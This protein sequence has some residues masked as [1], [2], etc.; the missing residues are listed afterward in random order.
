[1][2]SATYFD[3]R[4]EQLVDV[5]EDHR[6]ELSLLLARTRN[7]TTV[8]LDLSDLLN[9]GWL[10]A[11]DDP[12]QNAK[13]RL[14]KEVA[15]SGP[16]IVVT[17]GRTDARILKK[18]L[19]II[20]PDLQDWFAFLDFEGTSAPGGVDRV[21]SLTRGMAAAQVMNRVVAVLDNDTAGRGAAATLASSSLPS[22][23]KVTLLPS[24]EYAENYPT[25]GPAGDSHLNVNG[26]AA[27][28][29]M[30]FGLAVMETANEGRRPAVRWSSYDE[31][32]HDYQGMLEHKGDIQ[33]CIM[34]ELDVASS[35]ELS[36]E[37][38]AGCHRLSKMLIDAAGDLTPTSHPTSDSAPDRH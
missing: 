22:R 7:S 35:A 15:A 26:R 12:H 8:T 38:Y 16:I 33:K 4:W 13:L 19:M 5:F 18:A 31:R 20:E 30:M 37:I 21:V 34:K 10:A 11:S 3:S 24:V 14:A 25:K 28:I 32:I 23:M 1:V 17:E 27:T 36:P 2:N 6:F 9:G 29:E